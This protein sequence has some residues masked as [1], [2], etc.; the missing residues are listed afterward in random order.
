ME[1]APPLPFLSSAGDPDSLRD[2]LRQ[3]NLTEE[4]K[5]GA[6]SAQFETLMLNLFLKDAFQPALGGATGDEAS[7]GSGV[8]QHFVTTALADSITAAGGF[9]F[10][11][12]LQQQ[13]ASRPASAPQL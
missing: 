11:S 8:W 4:Q 13:L 2:L 1:I 12:I 3:P 10:T 7:S 5:I 9:G 6:V